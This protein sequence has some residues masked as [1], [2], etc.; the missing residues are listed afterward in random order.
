MENDIIKNF[1]AHIGFV[2]DLLD[3]NDADIKR[4]RMVKHILPEVVIFAER[5]LHPDNVNI[6]IGW[7]DLHDKE[8]FVVCQIHQREFFERYMAFQDHKE[9]YRKCVYALL[10]DTIKQVLYEF[11]TNIFIDATGEDGEKIIHR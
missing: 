2:E 4:W 10:G 1:Y 9:D 11:G 3:E 8:K 5:F 7:K 6:T